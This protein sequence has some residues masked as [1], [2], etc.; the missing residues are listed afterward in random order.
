MR[1]PGI[2]EEEEILAFISVMGRDLGYSGTE[3]GYLEAEVR[4]STGHVVKLLLDVNGLM[5]CNEHHDQ[6]N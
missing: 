4:F 3:E 2:E 6:V 1:T 5:L